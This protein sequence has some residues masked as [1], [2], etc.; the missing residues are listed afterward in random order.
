M[1]SVKSLVCCICSPKA[2]LL[3][4]LPQHHRRDSTP[5]STSPSYNGS[6][7]PQPY[8]PPL[9]HSNQGPLPGFPV[10]ADRPSYLQFQQP[11][12][13]QVNITCPLPSSQL[14]S[15]N[16]PSAPGH[17]AAPI[18]NIT[19]LYN[20]LLKDVCFHNPHRWWRGG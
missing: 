7:Y 3:C 20:V 13:E 15:L 6:S 1:I 5:V 14:A 17:S 10:P 18:S 4:L 16:S 2:P 19:N 11:K 8:F 12:T 9:L